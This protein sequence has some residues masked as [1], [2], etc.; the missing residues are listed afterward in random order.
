MNIIKSTTLAL[1]IGLPIVLLSFRC[2]SPA[3]ASNVTNADYSEA[4]MESAGENDKQSAV[5]KSPEKK[6]AIL[7]SVLSM[8]E[9]LHY[10]P[11]KINDEFASNVYDRFL[12]RIDY[13]KSYLLASDIKKIESNKKKIDDQLKDSKTDFYDQVKAI[14]DIRQAEIKT[15]YDELIAADYD[16]TKDETVQLDGK[17]LDWAKDQAELKD[18]WRKSIKYRILAKYVELMEE[19]DTKKDTVKDWVI[20]SDAKLRDSARVVVKKNMDYFFR[21]TAKSGDDEYFS[22]YVNSICSVIDPHTDFF[23]PKDKEKFDEQM[24]GTFFGIGA[25]LQNKDGVCVVSQIISGS[26]CWKQGRLKVDDKI[27]RVAQGSGEP[28][29]IGGWDI[30]DIVSKIRGKK[31]TEVRL[32]V[33]HKDG[34]DEIIPIIRDEVHQEDVFAKSFILQEGKNKVG[35]IFLPEFYADFNKAGGKRCAVDMANEVQKLKDENVDGI[36]IDL[37]GNGGGSLADVVDISSLFQG[38]GPTVQVK[39][40]DAASEPLANRKAN[41]T[42]YDGPLTIMVNGGSASA[43]EILAGA[44]Q[45]YKRAVVVG[46]TT[47]GKGTVQRVF[48]MD[49]FYGKYPLANN[50][51]LDEL[52]SLGAVKLTIQKFYRISGNSTQL[53]GV[54]PDVQFPDLYMYLEGGERRDK[55]ALPFDMTDK[56]SYSLRNMTKYD[57]AIAKS[58]ARIA[59]NG[60]FKIVEE[61]AKQ[62]KKQQDDNQYSL[63]LTKYKVQVQEAKDFAK[64]LEELEKTKELLDAYNCR[65]DMDKTL[66]DEVSKKKN[67]DWLKLLKKDAGIKEAFNVIKDLI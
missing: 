4:A 6:R 18:R 17:K 59:S 54:V 38:E 43:S 65:V 26:P 57:A 39:S 45:D 34:T 13:G 19:Q 8:V 9:E 63:N 27:L 56:L 41:G 52:G 12:E 58:K 64:K 50:P 11:K 15:Y 61:R 42:F 31:G 22:S 48:E 1:A 21:K 67:E 55:F 33:K 44:L 24:S 53:K 16:F 20:M 51:S 2:T 47:F 3:K 35:Y 7:Y 49:R 25:A 40:K 10:N 23:A 62:I 28:V 60:Y 30:D 14:L 36:I 37:R 46:S 32:T 66:E 29:D 5:L